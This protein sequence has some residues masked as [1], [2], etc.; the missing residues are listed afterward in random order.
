MEKPKRKRKTAHEMYMEAW[1]AGQADAF[2]RCAMIADGHRA[3]HLNSGCIREGIAASSVSAFII[4]QARE[5]GLWNDKRRQPL[6]LAECDKA[7]TG[8]EQEGD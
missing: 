7:P 2:L 3:M 8:T 1:R 5:W 6:I 4:Q